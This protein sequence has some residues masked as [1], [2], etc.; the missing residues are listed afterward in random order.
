MKSNNGNANFKRL[1]IS[2]GY[3]EIEGLKE[4]ISDELRID[5]Q[6]LNPFNNIESDIKIEHPSKY[7]VA[8]GLALRGLL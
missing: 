8:V 4:Q 5:S 6:I 2:G 7:C 3:S 1:F